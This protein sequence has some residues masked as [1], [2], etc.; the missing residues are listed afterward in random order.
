MGYR[1]LLVDNDP[2]ASITKGLG[3]IMP[4]QLDNVL[5]KLYDDVMSGD[6]VRTENFI[7]KDLCDGIDIIPTNISLASRE[8]N[9]MMA[10]NRE[11]I[12]KRILMPIKDQ[13]DYILIDTPPTMGVFM[14]NSLA[15]SDIVTIPSVPD[16]YSFL[17]VAEL[18]RTIKK[19]ISAL[20]D[21]LS[22]GGI[23]ITKARMHTRNDKEV[24]QALKSYE[25][26]VHVYDTIIP[27][28]TKGTEA[29]LRGMTILD[30]APRSKVAEAYRILAKEILKNGEKENRA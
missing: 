24:I 12:L 15:A 16:S 19:A 1:V 9:I 25:E 17:G 8:T 26:K 3:I 18:I 23:F 6:A 27:L 14:L 28:D 22:I 2:Q 13:Y 29:S 11:H 7:V 20:N 10:M 21:N 5:T 4:D 30:F